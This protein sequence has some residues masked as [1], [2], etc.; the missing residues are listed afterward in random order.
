MSAPLRPRFVNWSFTASASIVGLRLGRTA[1]GDAPASLRW[2]GNEMITV[3]VHTFSIGREHSQAFVSGFVSQS[4]SFQRENTIKADLRYAGAPEL[5]A[6][7]PKT[8]FVL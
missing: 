3:G 5:I 8:C 6:N 4:R 2:R 7:L 1:C